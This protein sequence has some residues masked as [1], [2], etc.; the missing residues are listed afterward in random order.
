MRSSCRSRPESFDLVMASLSLH[1]INDLPG[2][3]IQL[4]QSAAAGRVVSGVDACAGEFGE[5]RAAL[6]EA[7][8]ALSG[9]ASPRVSPFP[10]L[11]DCAGL[12]QRAG[13]RRRSSIW[14][15]SSFATRIHCNCY[16]ICGQRERQTRSGR[17][18]GPYRQRNCFPR[19]W[20]E[21]ERRMGGYR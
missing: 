8:L 18:R 13:S 3:L 15:K 17:G 2:A 14:R 6:T 21:C 9:G 19:P 5:L 16:A 11:R 1:W 12:L 20:K 4:R 10:D 7:E